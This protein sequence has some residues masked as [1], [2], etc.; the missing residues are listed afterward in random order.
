MGLF[1]VIG[2]GKSSRV[3]QDPV[4]YGSRK[5]GKQNR[6][7]GFGPILGALIRIEGTKLAA[8]AG[9]NPLDLGLIR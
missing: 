8:T 2:F 6:G 5:P 1:V 9:Y 4:K 7:F 3:T